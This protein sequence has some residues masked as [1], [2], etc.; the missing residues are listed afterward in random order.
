MPHGKQ[1]ENQVDGQVYAIS[2]YIRCMLQTTQRKLEL[3]YRLRIADSGTQSTRH[4]SLCCIHG[5]ERN[6]QPDPFPYW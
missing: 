6:L 2:Y 4:T 5:K 1:Q 3:C